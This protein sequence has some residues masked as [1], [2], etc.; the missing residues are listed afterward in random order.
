MALEMKYMPTTR[1][2]EVMDLSEYLNGE[3]ER[4]IVRDY[5]MEADSWSYIYQQ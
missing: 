5:Q 3:E 1:A 2:T 4:P